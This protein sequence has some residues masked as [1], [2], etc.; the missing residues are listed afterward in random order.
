MR[1]MQAALISQPG[2]PFMD[3][4]DSIQLLQMLF[5]QNQSEIEPGAIFAG[6]WIYR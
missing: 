5:R 1:G 6:N 2:V 3:H 4:I